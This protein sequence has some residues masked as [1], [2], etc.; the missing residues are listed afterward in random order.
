MIKTEQDKMID[1]LR[2]KIIGLEIKL[3]LTE[4]KLKK[5]KKVEE[6]NG[7]FIETSSPRV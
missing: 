3:A 5:P 1:T 4:A 2:E 7:W 6:P